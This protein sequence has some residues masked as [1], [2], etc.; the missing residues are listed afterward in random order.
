MTMSM[1]LIFPSTGGSD[2]AV[3]SFLSRS[4]NHYPVT[5]LDCIQGEEAGFLHKLQKGYVE[6]KQDILAY[7]H[8]DVR[9]CEDDWDTR[10]LKEFED[11]TV[12]VVGFGGGKRLGSPDIYKLPYRLQQLARFDFVSNLTDAPVHGRRNRNEEDIAV[13]DGFCMIV[14]REFLA[15][16]GGW[17]IVEYSPFHCYDTWVCCMA[18]RCGYRVRM[19]GVSCSHTG[20]GVRGNGEFDYGKWQEEIGLSDQEMHRKN[21]LSLYQNFRDVLPIIV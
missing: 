5:V 10:V 9:C 19:V 12:G 14:R 17:P 20:G 11:P 6:L 3:N 2:E 13:V 21:H 15:K 8:T 1:D 18:R 7:F 4:I 16:V